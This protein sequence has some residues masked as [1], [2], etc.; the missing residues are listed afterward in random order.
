MPFQKPA[1]LPPYIVGHPQ[2]R[3]FPFVTQYNFLPTRGPR[4]HLNG[5]QGV[6]HGQT[7]SPDDE[8]AA[9]AHFRKLA[10]AFE[11][12]ATLGLCERFSI[13][14]V[15]S[16]EKAKVLKELDDVTPPQVGHESRVSQ[17][18]R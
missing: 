15:L 18:A 7:F 5:S 6:G 2:T 8:V 4:H 12:P 9:A 17:I 10:K 11:R 14:A 16:E 13:P 1:K 3:S